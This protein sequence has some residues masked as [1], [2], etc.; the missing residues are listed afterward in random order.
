[1]S[2]NTLHKADGSFSLICLSLCSR[3]H[4]EPSLGGA[5]FSMGSFVVA[6]CTLVTL[7]LLVHGRPH[8]GVPSSRTNCWSLQGDG[9][10]PGPFGVAVCALCALSFR[11]KF[12]RQTP[13]H[14]AH[15]YF[16]V[17]HTHDHLTGCTYTG[18]MCITTYSPRTTKER[19]AKRGTTGAREEKEEEGWKGLRTLLHFRSG[20]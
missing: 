20:H 14:Y 6:S 12:Q 18:W 9:E 4:V 15:L 5:C 3:S 2:L 1:M 8:H 11:L 16:Y 13:S 19:E 17:F 7:F 10:W